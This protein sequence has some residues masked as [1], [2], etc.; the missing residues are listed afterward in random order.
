MQVDAVV[1]DADRVVEADGATR[2][3]HLV[4]DVLLDDGAQRADPPGLADVRRLRQTVGRAA[5]HVGPETQSREAALRLHPVEERA[6]Q[7]PRARVVGLVEQRRVG[8]VDLRPVDEGD[9]AGIGTRLE[10]AA[11]GDAAEPPEVLVELW[12]VE[13]RADLERVL[14]GIVLEPA[15]DRPEVLRVGGDPPETLG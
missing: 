10:Q 9:V 2:A 15:R 11:R 12:V 1:P 6:A 7:R 14:T 3:S 5:D 8:V 4:G 13:V